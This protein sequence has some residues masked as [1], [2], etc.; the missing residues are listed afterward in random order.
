MGLDNKYSYASNIR[1]SSL[2]TPVVL[3]TFVSKVHTCYWNRDLWMLFRLMQNIYT[4]ASYKDLWRSRDARLQ[5]SKDAR[6]QRF[7]DARLQDQGRTHTFCLVDRANLWPHCDSVS[8]ELATWY[9]R[10]EGKLQGRCV[11]KGLYPSIFG[12]SS[13]SETPGQLLLKYQCHMWCI[14]CSIWK[15]RY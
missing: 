8:F 9:F 4:I 10:F 13:Q 14:A 2:L 1:S 3:K 7:R 11:D 12:V 5:R 15:G 6:L